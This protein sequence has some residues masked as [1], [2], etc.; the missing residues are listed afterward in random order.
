[1]HTKEK[2][3]EVLERRAISRVDADLLKLF[4]LFSQIVG[5]HDGP[6]L[7]RLKEDGTLSVLEG[8]PTTLYFLLKFEKRSGADHVSSSGF[9]DEL[10][11]DLLPRYRDAVIKEFMDKV[12]QLG[13]QEECEG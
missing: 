3:A 9:M 10:R 7:S 8:S 11:A 12:D 2:L 4:N 5:A 6:R 13:L 1:M